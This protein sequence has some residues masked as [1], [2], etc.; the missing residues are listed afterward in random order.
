MQKK[1]LTKMVLEQTPPKGERLEIRDSESPLAFRISESGVRSL[2]VRTR[3]RGE[4]IR[5]T[6]PKS[7]TI[8]NLSEARQ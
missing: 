6:F 2:T 5:L 4:Q 8:E 7:A 3:F 1:R